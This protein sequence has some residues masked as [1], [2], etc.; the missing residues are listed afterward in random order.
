MA[1]TT[2]NNPRAEIHL[3]LYYGQLQDNF[4]LL[5]LAFRVSF[6]PFPMESF[7]DFGSRSRALLMCR[8]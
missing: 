4:R 6:I 3:L 5:Y 7:L 1:G 2:V 8:G